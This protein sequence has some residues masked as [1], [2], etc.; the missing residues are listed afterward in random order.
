MD[1]IM[2]SAT[3]RRRTGSGASLF[4][5]PA[6]SFTLAASKVLPVWLS[7]VTQPVMSSV[8]PFSGA[9]RL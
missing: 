4:T 2:V 6:M 5:S 8:S 1:M 7:I 3:S 9:M